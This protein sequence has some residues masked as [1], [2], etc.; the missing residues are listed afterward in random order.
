MG[1]Y[2]YD[3]M[4]FRCWAHLI[5]V[6]GISKIKKGELSMLSL[7]CGSFLYCFLAIAS[8][9]RISL[10][11]V[12][13]PKLGNTK[14]SQFMAVLVIYQRATFFYPSSRRINLHFNYIDRPLFLS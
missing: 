11:L 8:Y 5:F 9:A 1:N 2:A 14:L 12:C 3:F 13:V 6:I 10:C 7:Y 4:V